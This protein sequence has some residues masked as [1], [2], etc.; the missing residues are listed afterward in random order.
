M[1]DNL[2]RRSIP[3]LNAVIPLAFAFA[4]GAIFTMIA[5]YNPLTVY[6][7][8][9][10]TAFTSGG[11]WMQTL[12]FACPI[13]L[14]GIATAFAFQSGLWNIGVEGQLYFG[15][16]AA[17][18][19]GAGYFGLDC[20]PVGL[21]MPLSVLAGILAGM[22]YA[23]IPALLKAYLNANVVVTTIM[24]NYIAI[25]LTEF[26]TKAFFQGDQ[27]YDST[28]AIQE[29]AEIPKIMSRY[30]VSY[31]IFLAVA[32]VLVVWFVSRRTSF[33]YEISAIGRQLEFSEAVGMR[34]RKK[35]V[36]IFLISGAIAGVAGATEVLGVNKNFM[37]NFSTNPGLG[38][39]G[40]YVAV[41]AHNN[42]LAV[43]LIAIIFG[44][45]RYGS[46]AVQSKLGVPLDLLNI[47]QGA[48]I[49]FYSIK[50]FHENK[51]KIQKHMKKANPA[52]KEEQQNA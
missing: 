7:L 12:G 1:S 39:Q 2:K 28:Y 20:I 42:P 11:G 40:Y 32:I 29:T 35:I 49:L 36:L 26:L 33:G 45:F 9:L 13:I 18:L 19:V 44:G 50:Y 30:R 10:K 48:L 8:I 15:A 43:L 6:G 5:G 38:W 46:I 22:L 41:L 34:V 21:Q 25:E 4:L 24:L 37:P 23:A 27:S 47:I 31:A 51:E 16:F 14:T 52:K 17:A 3:V